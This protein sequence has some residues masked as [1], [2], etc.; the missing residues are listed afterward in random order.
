MK[1]Q[2]EKHMHRLMAVLLVCCV[3]AVVLPGWALEWSDLKRDLA[4]PNKKARLLAI[5]RLETY[6]GPERVPLLLGA[7]KDP[8]LTNRQTAIQLLGHTGDKRAVLPLVDRLKNTPDVTSRYFC[9]LALGQLRDQRALPAVRPWHLS[10]D[11]L[12][13]TSSAAAMSLL[14]DPSGFPVILKALQSPKALERSNAVSALSL[15][16]RSHAH[17]LLPLLRDEN[18]EVRADVLFALSK[19]KDPALLS[20]FLQ[21]LQDSDGQV[22]S[23]ALYAIVDLGADAKTHWARLLPLLSD[24]DPTVRVN[25]VLALAEVDPQALRPHLH[26]L[27]KDAEPDVKAVAAETLGQWGVASDIPYLKQ[28]LILELQP[29]TQDILRK[30]LV[31]LQARVAQKEPA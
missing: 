15:L 14:G 12:M 18:A 3:W 22:R 1:Q 4:S 26:G 5:R 9:I 31:K 23:A 8:D 16:D 30:S 19:H 27:L 17:L 6:P 20:A 13:A 24:T 21:S 25:A 28:A 7:L 2:W 11:S 10:S 29:V